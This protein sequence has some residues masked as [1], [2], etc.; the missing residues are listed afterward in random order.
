MVSYSSNSVWIKRQN[1]VQSLSGLSRVKPEVTK[2]VQANLRLLTQL[3]YSSVI[4]A[5]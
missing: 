4:N 1:H 2:P 3:N 5:F